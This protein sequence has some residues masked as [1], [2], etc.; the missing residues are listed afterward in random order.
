ML[1]YSLELVSLSG[2]FHG[3]Q[4]IDVVW[5][6]VVRAK[7]VLSFPRASTGKAHRPQFLHKGVTFYGCGV[8]QSVGEWVHRKRESS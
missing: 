2:H 8:Q 7:L 3:V 4:V 6:R 1:G 5:E